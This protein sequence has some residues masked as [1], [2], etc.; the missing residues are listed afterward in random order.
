MASLQQLWGSARPLNRTF[1]PEQVRD[2]PEPARRYLEHAIDPG[3][4]L[5]AAVR[6]RMHGE[7][8]LKDWCP[9]SAEQ[10]ICWNRGFVWQGTARMGL[11][12]IRGSDRF[13]DGRGAMHWALFGIVPFIK[14]SSPD[15]TRAAAG[16]LNLETIWLP[17]A[18]CAMDVAWTAPEPSRAHARF[19]AHGETAEIDLVIS[20]S[21][22]VKSGSL[23]RWGNPRG[24]AF[25]YE[26]FGGFMEREEKFGGYVIPVAMR[27]G[28]YFGTPRYETDG[29]FFRVTIDGAEYR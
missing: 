1:G 5:A 3:T 23:P 19:V 24:S 4:P 6:L 17:S 7:I 21:G 26:Q 14:A 13:L 15:I 12:P 10:V 11:I 29:E 27:A 16:R 28:W 22:K 25:H 18:L 20:D 8:K 9:F 2:L